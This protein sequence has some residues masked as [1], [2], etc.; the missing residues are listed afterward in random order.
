MRTD[1]H[2]VLSRDFFLQ[3]PVAGGERL[4]WFN[5]EGWNPGSPDNP[6]LGLRVTPAFNYNGPLLTS[7]LVSRWVIL[8]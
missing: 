7:L 5:R 3:V 4:F 2:I 8:K 1:A 6:N